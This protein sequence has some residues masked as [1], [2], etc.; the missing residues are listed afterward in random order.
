MKAYNRQRIVAC[1]LWCVVGLVSPSVVD[2]H[3]SHLSAGK[4][5][6]REDIERLQALGAKVFEK[7]G[8]V[9][10]VILDR[11]HVV[12]ADLRLLAGF[13]ELTDLSL[14]QCRVGDAGMA[15]LVGLKKLEWVNLYETEVGDD[16]LL[17]LKR[18]PLLQ[19]LPLG[20]TRVTDQGL[21][22][23]AEMPQLL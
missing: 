14:E 13:Q 1:L 3:G 15:H 16:S 12:D 11:T 23:L 7:A 19:H 21:L 5:D 2:G 17:L 20:R 9:V 8:K 10:E 18:L 22:Q 4:A 6:V